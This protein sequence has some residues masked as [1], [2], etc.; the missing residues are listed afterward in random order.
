MTSNV[1]VCVVPEADAEDAIGEFELQDMLPARS[2][3]LD[4]LSVGN[5]LCDLTDDEVE[6]VE[7]GSS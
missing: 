6:P 7:G 3:T 2:R 4:R 1:D 5:D